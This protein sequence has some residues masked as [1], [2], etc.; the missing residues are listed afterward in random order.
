MIYVLSL[1]LLTLFA[2]QS[3]MAKNQ[4][5][6]ACETLEKLAE[7]V[8]KARQEGASMSALYMKDYGSSDRNK[9]MKSLVK[10][11]Y[12]KPRF[13]SQQ[14]KTDAINDFKNEKFSYCI[15][16]LK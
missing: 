6:L 2:S 8:M 7:A 10:E 16:N 1:I 15:E 9:I 4:N 3:V 14:S 12:K 13:N 11:A 5:E